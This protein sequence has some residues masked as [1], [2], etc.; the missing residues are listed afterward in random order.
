VVDSGGVLDLPEAGEQV[1]G[2]QS[3]VGSSD[4]WSSG[5]IASR[6]RD[7]ERP[8]DAQ[9]P[10]SFGLGMDASVRCE[11]GQTE[12]IIGCVGAKGRW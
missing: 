9:T 3:G 1:D 8:E 10:A 4:A 7:E 2:V 5:P 11:L 6:S 12:G